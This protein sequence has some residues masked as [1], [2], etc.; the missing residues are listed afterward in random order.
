M[1][2]W[3]WSV[4]AAAATGSMVVAQ[5]VAV[6]ELGWRMGTLVDLAFG[7]VCLL[8]FCTR[9]SPE[10]AV[11]WGWKGVTAAAFAGLLGAT[12]FVSS[13]RALSLTEVTRAMPIVAAA[14][15]VTVLL[16]FLVLRESVTLM[17]AVGMAMAIS[18][19]YLVAIS[20]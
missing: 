20:E 8:F 18:G 9:G 1:T 13:N 19:A 11:R 17:Q 16:A 6:R 4:L 7:V 15:V 3:A 2:W 14:P 10:V 5:K 12:A